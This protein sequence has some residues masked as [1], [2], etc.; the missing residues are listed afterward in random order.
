MPIMRIAPRERL[1][2]PQGPVQA[3]KYLAW[4][5]GVLGWSAVTGLRGTFMSPRVVSLVLAYPAA[6]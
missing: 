1:L 3:T 2:L 4:I 6:V 5:S